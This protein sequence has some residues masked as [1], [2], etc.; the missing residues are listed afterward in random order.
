MW[1]ERYGSDEF[2]YGKAPNGFLKSAA[3]VGA[4]SS[5]GSLAHIRSANAATSVNWLSWGG[6]VE[7]S[8]IKSFYDATGIKVNPIGMNSNA[9]TFAKLKL[10]GATQYDLFEADCQGIII[11]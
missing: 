7:P 1:N 9:A 10:S 4:L 5:A 11:S 2:I 3:A 8:G 6:H